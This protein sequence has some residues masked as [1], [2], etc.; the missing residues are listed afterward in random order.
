MVSS[1]EKKVPWVLDLVG[2]QKTDGFERIFASI[3]VITQKEVVAFRWEFTMIE[4]PEQIGV[5]S[6]NVALI[7]LYKIPQILSGD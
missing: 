6:M 3:D 7:N 2:K 5:L 4:K 1:Q